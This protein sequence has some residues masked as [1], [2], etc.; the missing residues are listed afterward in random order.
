MLH[1]A[2]PI[3]PVRRNASAN[4]GGLSVSASAC[5]ETPMPASTPPPSSI[6]PPL[7]AWGATS[8][9]EAVRVSADLHERLA[10]GARMLAAFDL[11]LRRCEG[12]I[13]EHESF[14]RRIEESA[15]HAASRLGELQPIA[16]KAANGFS[17]RLD[18]LLR[19]RI[20]EWQRRAAS[21]GEEMLRV[22][23]AEI[24]ARH[25]RAAAAEDRLQ[26]AEQRLERIESSLADAS[27]RFAR[28]LREHSE[29]HHRQRED[30]V[31]AVRAASGELLNAM[32]RAEQVRHALEEDLRQ[33]SDLL[34]RCRE[35]DR[36]IRDGV[37]RQLA[38]VR[39]TAARLD[40]ARNELAPHSEQARLLGDRL[41]RLLVA[42]REW[43]PLLENQLPD[44]LR[45]QA[46]LAFREGARRLGEQVDRVSH[47]FLSLSHLMGGTGSDAGEAMQRGPR[48][49]HASNPRDGSFG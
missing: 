41:E 16:E 2:P 38:S 11:Q 47:A 44:R 4:E 32:Q 17:L 3:P 25:A 22:L 9:A 45:E 1:G 37:E 13:A 5:P 26:H 49:G 39:E 40:N 24:N 12:S 36:E 27:E 18:S 29:Q 7:G 34:Q 48:A 6:T 23:E 21:H 35:L 30:A 14:A 8:T 46:E 10:L 33:R 20:E 15:E 28:E 19:E 43:T 42:L 31:L